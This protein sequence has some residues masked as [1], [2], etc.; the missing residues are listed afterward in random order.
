MPWRFKRADGTLWGLAG[1]WSTWTDKATGE[2]V[3]SF[4]MLT[5]NADAHPLVSRMH[6]PDSKRPPHLRDKRS[7]V[8]I[9]LEDVDAWLF[10][11]PSEAQALVR[12]AAPE[13][14]DAFPAG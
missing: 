14:F 2:I 9:R 1:L 5:L 6:R 13:V 3:E 8:P 11:T 4:T 10:G 12:L 7:V